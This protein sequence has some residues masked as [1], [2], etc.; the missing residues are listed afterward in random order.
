M[1]YAIPAA[2]AASLVFPRKQVISFVGDG[3]FLMSGLEISTA[4]QQGLSMVI[5]IIN[6]ASYGTIRMHQE[7]KYPNRVI[8]TDIKN[9]DFVSLVRSMGGYAEKVTTSDEFFNVF[10]QVIKLRQVSVIELVV[11]KENISSRLELKDILKFK[12]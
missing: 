1:G 5:V 10:E 11:P 9:P 8:G 3:G 4:I 12:Q 6:N 7:L 2:I